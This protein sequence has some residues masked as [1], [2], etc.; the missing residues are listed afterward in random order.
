M[1][2]NTNKLFTKENNTQIKYLSSIKKP[3][4]HGRGGLKIMGKKKE[5]KFTIN[6]RK[7]KVAVSSEE[8]Q[9][10]K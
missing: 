9:D 2:K 5:E 8:Q 3:I 10:R 7:S 4:Y 6:S 1:Y